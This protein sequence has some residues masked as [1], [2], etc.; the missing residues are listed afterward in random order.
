[1]IIKPNLA[2][3]KI[4]LGLSKLN[5]KNKNTQEKIDS[6]P[7]LTFALDKFMNTSKD[8][9]LFD[10]KSQHE[11]KKDAD[12]EI[13]YSDEEEVLPKKLT[14][15]KCPFKPNQEKKKVLLERC[16]PIGL[17]KKRRTNISKK[18]TNDNLKQTKLTLDKFKFANKASVL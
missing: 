8:K 3:G 14:S 10:S 17:T 7:K 15:K 1:M 5:R 2:K 11:S 13:I 6:L 4:K 16:K 9:I 18:S 12:I